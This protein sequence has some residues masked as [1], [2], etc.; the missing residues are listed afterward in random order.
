MWWLGTTT[1]KRKN[2]ARSERRQHHHHYYHQR[3][4]QYQHEQ[5]KNSFLQVQGDFRLVDGLV[6]GQSS[7]PSTS[8]P[9]TAAGG[10]ENDGEGSTTGAGIVH[11]GGE[12]EARAGGR[13]KRKRTRRQLIGQRATTD[14]DE[15]DVEEA[16][17]RDQGVEGVVV[18]VENAE[19]ASVILDAFGGFGEVARAGD[20]AVAVGAGVGGTDAG[21]GHE[22]HGEYEATFIGN[23]DD[24]N[25][26][27]EGVL[28][29]AMIVEGGNVLVEEEE[30]LEDGYGHGHE[31]KWS[32]RWLE[33]KW[34]AATNKN[35][36]GKRAHED[37]VDGFD[38]SDNSIADAGGGRGRN[39]GRDGGV[40][41][42]WEGDE[43]DG[44]VWGQGRR[45]L[46]VIGRGQGRKKGRQTRAKADS[47]EVQLYVGVAL[48]VRGQVAQG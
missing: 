21:H 20:I 4:R 28:G 12:G 1:T 42:E 29:F 9:Q 36:H 16:G 31:L 47:D 38:R 14:S 30:G 8:A 35:V 43:E 13:G 48:T 46:S 7:P 33:R 25:D 19:F 27:D 23:N 26:N 5:R 10:A 39:E 3:Q 34:S 2:N 24:N 15:E 45:M 41:V 18:G 22:E 6:P 37:D 40:F 17:G 11:G 32:S 44:G